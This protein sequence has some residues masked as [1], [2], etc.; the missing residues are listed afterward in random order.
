MDQNQI[1]EKAPAW[2]WVVFS[3]LVLA[4][5]GFIAWAIFVKPMVEVKSL[6]N[7]DGLPTDVVKDDTIDP[8]EASP[9]VSPSVVS[10]TDWKTYENKDLG[11]S[12][13]YPSDFTMNVQN[14]S[15]KTGDIPWLIDVK[16]SNNSVADEGFGIEVY[17]NLA[18]LT[19]AQINTT[20]AHTGDAESAK[21]GFSNYKETTLD[22]INAFSG[23]D[24]CCGTGN[25]NVVAVYGN[26]VYKLTYSSGP[27]SSNL[28]GS[29]F[30][31]F[32]DSFKFAK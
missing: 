7:K 32:V 4:L 18:G 31:N 14:G 3:L 27:M 6:V 2:L 16:F 30:N 9:S 8:V 12:V 23:G 5:L 26:Y 21:Q 1:S 19:L 20:I 29:S 13:K 10:T 17:N 11:F 15:L 25:S 24:G 28:Y 22:K